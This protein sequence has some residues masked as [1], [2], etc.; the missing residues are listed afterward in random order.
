MQG[1]HEVKPVA[2]ASGAAPPSW[3]EAASVLPVPVVMA[4]PVVPQIVPIVPAV[5][6]VVATSPGLFTASLSVDGV[7]FS[8]AIA[9]LPLLVAPLPRFRAGVLVDA[10]PSFLGAAG[11]LAMSSSRPKDA[12]DRARQ[13]IARARSNSWEA[14]ASDLLRTDFTRRRRIGE[15]IWSLKLHPNLR[16]DAGQASKPVEADRFL[17]RMSGKRRHRFVRLLQRVEAKSFR[18]KE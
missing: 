13:T 11:F 3:V 2:A 17:R 10:A 9:V 14:A 1:Q 15:L 16:Q 5:P 12:T 6:I 7:S 4:V 18:H 8:S